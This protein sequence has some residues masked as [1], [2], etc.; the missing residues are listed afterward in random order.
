MV[1]AFPLSTRRK[2]G[3]TC[4]CAFG[5]LFLSTPPPE[6]LP[7][8]DLRTVGGVFPDKPSLNLMDTVR[9]V[10]RKQDWYLEYLQD[11][12]RSVLSFVGSFSIRSPIKRWLQIFG[13][14]LA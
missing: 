13:A 9:D 14:Y 5:Y 8:P 7:L 1:R 6:Q 2:V 11:H 12:E 10:L 4:A 3:C